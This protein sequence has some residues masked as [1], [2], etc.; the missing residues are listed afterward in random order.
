MSIEKKFRERMRKNIERMYDERRQPQ[1][2][3]EWNKYDKG[4]AFDSQHN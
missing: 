4:V 1:A 2:Q 3:C